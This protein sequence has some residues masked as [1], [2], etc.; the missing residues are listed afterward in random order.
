MISPYSVQ[1]RNEYKSTE[2]LLLWIHKLLV[3]LFNTNLHVYF[4]GHKNN[5]AAIK[6]R[7]RLKSLD[8]HSYQPPQNSF[9]NIINEIKRRGNLQ[10]SS[11]Q[12]PAG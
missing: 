8:K 10:I 3:G 12:Y 4:A 5:T 7:Q 9:K 6:I 1:R 2:K 11:I